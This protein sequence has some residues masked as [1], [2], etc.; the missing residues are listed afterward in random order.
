[1]WYT[2]DMN[3][4]SNTYTGVLERDVDGGGYVATCPA[5]P[6]VVTGGDTVEQTMDRARDAVRGYLENLAL[7]TAKP[8]QSSGI[9]FSAPSR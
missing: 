6:G 5:L 1:V 7:S 2:L 3:Q 9:R 8:F 4:S